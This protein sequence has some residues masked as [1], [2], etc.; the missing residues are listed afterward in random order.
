MNVRVALSAGC[1]RWCDDC[2][3]G[4]VGVAGA[5][6]LTVRMALPKLPPLAADCA[7]GA[8]EVAAASR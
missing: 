1:R 6:A 7:R 8:A 2:Q 3:R 4:A 5:G